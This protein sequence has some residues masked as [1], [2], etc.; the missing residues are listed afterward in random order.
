MSNLDKYLRTMLDHHGYL[1]LRGTTVAQL[2]AFALQRRAQD[3]SPIEIDEFEDLL[4]TVY[5]H[6]VLTAMDELVRVEKILCTRQ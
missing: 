5:I 4:R 2:L 6:R 3:R 1:L